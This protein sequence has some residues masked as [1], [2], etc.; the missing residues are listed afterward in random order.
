MAD[1]R[2]FVV[3]LDPARR[4]R[5]RSLLTDVGQLDA[6]GAWWGP[7]VGLRGVGV[8]VGS[9]NQRLHADLSVGCNLVRHQKAGQL[10][11]RISRYSPPRCVCD[12]LVPVRIVSDDPLGAVNDIID[13]R[14][15]G[16]R[17]S[18]LGHLVV[19]T[20]IVGN[21]PSHGALS[22]RSHAPVPRNGPK[23]R[24]VLFVEGTG[25]QEHRVVRNVGLRR[26]DL[27]P[28]R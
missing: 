14:R 20:P 28:D 22:L 10:V 15:T 23:G 1:L 18:V 27:P 17:R 9:W 4:V 3:C 7:L 6:V 12:R 11:D 19:E 26:G 13:A 21:A 25:R 24:D 5:A 8:R 16:G 2:R